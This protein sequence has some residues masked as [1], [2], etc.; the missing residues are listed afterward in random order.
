MEENLTKSKKGYSVFFFYV[1]LLRSFLSWKHIL[2]FIM[3]RKV[4]YVNWETRGTK[5]NTWRNYFSCFQVKYIFQ[6]QN[7]KEENDN[8]SFSNVISTKV[9]TLS[10]TYS[11]LINY[12]YLHL[13]CSCMNIHSRVAQSQWFIFLCQL[14]STLQ[15]TTVCAHNNLFQAPDLLCYW[16]R[17]AKLLIFSWMH[18]P[19]TLHYDCTLLICWNEHIIFLQPQGFQACT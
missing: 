14:R 2:L 19:Q 9:K 4:L 11:H 13:G 7:W 17:A 10:A 8:G 18:I 5:A 1:W 3:I 16:G 6:R 12:R 15:Y